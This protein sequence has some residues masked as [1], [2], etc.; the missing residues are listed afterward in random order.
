M[1][2]NRRLPKVRQDQFAMVPRADVPRSRFSTRHTYKTTFDVDRLVPFFVDECLP[3]DDFRGKVTAFVR[4]ATPLFPV[5]DNLTAEMFF[6][7]TPC[8]L[9]WENWTK[10]MGERVTPTA[11]ISAYTVPQVACQGVDA[12]GF[13]PLTP[14]DY[15]GLPVTGQ[16]SSPK[17]VNA[18]PFRCLNLI[19]NEW[20]RPQDLM[21]LYP[22]GGTPTD[23]GPDAAGVINNPLWRAK[24]HDYFTSALPWPVKANDV[25]TIPLG[26]R[27]PVYGIGAISPAAVLTGGPYRETDGSAL[28]SHGTGIVGYNAH[29]TNTVALWARAEGGNNVPDVYADLSE[30][31]GAT[32]NAIRLAVAT[33]QLLERDAR[34]GSRYTELLRNHFG[35][36][37]EDARLQRPEYIGGGKFFL[38]TQAIPQTSASEVGG[39]PLGELGAATLGSGPGS[40]S[41]TCRE[42]GYIIGI[43]NIT[44]DITYQQGVHRMFTRLT[45]YD[46]YWPTFA[47]LGEQAIRNDELYAD[48]SVNDTATFGYQ[49]RWA[50]YRYRPGRI[51]GLF[52]SNVA[53][54]IDQWHLA[55]D[56]ASLPAL[57]ATFIQ[58][59]TPLGRVLAADDLATGMQ[60]LL[61]SVFEISCTR[62]LPFRS[63]PGLTR[64]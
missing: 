35:V 7:F 60:F 11:N 22:A 9:V 18:L 17:T 42:H 55:E 28:G 20:F 13:D 34:G 25:P 45:R 14:G 50:E 62:A 16:L 59:A 36:M 32:L 58:Q 15:F 44:G 33:Q 26:A 21:G 2:L 56:F 31:T 49:E 47:F 61:D 52:R 19:W 8:R 24:R 6:F 64:F 30:A 1:S 57:N 43:I 48:G 23:D 53:G 29:L 3:G 4:M 51:T 37:P 38:Q 5:M 27:A 10:F 41:Y 54:S 39:T 63:V 12:T 40:F 46:F